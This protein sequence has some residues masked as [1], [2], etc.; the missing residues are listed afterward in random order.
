MVFD[1]T[2]SCKS[3]VDYFRTSCLKTLDIL[4]VVGNT[5]WGVDPKSLRCLYRSLVR[6]KLDCGCIVHGAASTDVE[7]D[8][9][10]Q[11]GLRITLGVFPTSPAT[12]LSVSFKNR[13]K[14]LPTSDVLNLKTCLDN[15][16]YG[17]VFEPPNLKLFEKSKLTSPLSL[18]ILPL[19]EDSKIDMDVTDDVTVS[20]NSPRS[21][22]EHQICLSGNLKKKKSAENP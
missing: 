22:F 10:H 13:C 6:S 20:D 9:I 3:H 8:P 18:R 1:R 7:L 17:C 19:F 11:Q 2:L 14:K 4:K 12:S 16:A 5:D 21:Q 15:P